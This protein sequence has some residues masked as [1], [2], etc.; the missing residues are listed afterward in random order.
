MSAARP[1]WRGTTQTS[2]LTSC[3]ERPALESVHSNKSSLKLSSTQ[4]FICVCTWDISAQSFFFLDT[5]WWYQKK[6]KKITDDSCKSKTIHTIRRKKRDNSTPSNNK[7]DYIFE[8]LMIHFVSF[9]FVGLGLLCF[10]HSAPP[11]L[12]SDTKLVPMTRFYS[13]RIGN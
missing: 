1:W 10:S 4:L 9:L 5:S 2:S 12:M 13:H 3:P 6:K 7:P 11:S 8:Y